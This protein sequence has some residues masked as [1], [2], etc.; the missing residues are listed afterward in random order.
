[1]DSCESGRILPITQDFKMPISLFK[2][3]LLQGLKSLGGNEVKTIPHAIKLVLGIALGN[4]T[5]GTFKFRNIRT[6]ANKQRD[7]PSG[8]GCFRSNRRRQ[9]I[10]SEVTFK[11]I[12]GSKRIDKI[13]LDRNTLIS[14]NFQRGLVR[15][16]HAIGTE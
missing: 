8:V 15:A 10:F 7:M 1:M 16:I 5:D 4:E 11:V 14:Q 6:H 2:A 9:F 13:G 12:F 3:C